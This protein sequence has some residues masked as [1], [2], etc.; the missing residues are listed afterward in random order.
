[1]KYSST[2]TISYKRVLLVKIA[3]LVYITKKQYNSQ[4]VIS[5]KP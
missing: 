4:L 1:M 2:F 5:N 3:E